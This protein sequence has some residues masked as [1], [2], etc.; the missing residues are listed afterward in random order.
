LWVFSYNPGGAFNM[1][2]GKPL[3]EKDPDLTHKQQPLTFE[4]IIH[5]LSSKLSDI[6]IRR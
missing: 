2:V 4:S 6:Q 5:F 1:H 3:D